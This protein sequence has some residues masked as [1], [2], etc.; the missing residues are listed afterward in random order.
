MITARPMRLQD[1]PSPCQH[2][3]K[4]NF[5]HINPKTHSFLFRPLHTQMKIFS[6]KPLIGQLTFSRPPVGLF[7]HCLATVAI[8]ICK[9][10]MNS[11]STHHDGTYLCE[12]FII[13]KRETTILSYLTFN[14]LETQ[15]QLSHSIFF[16]FFLFLMS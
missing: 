1:S 12:S 5:V 6:T 15:G 11:W 10:E 8:L 3:S 16:L 7:Q 4:Y 9:N 13:C 2:A 14:W